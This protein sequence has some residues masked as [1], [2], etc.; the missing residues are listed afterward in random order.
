MRI[1][2]GDPDVVAP[3]L[4]GLETFESLARFL[5]A[6]E[7]VINQSQ[8]MIAR[9]AFGPGFDDAQRLLVPTFENLRERADLV[10]LRWIE[11]EYFC[12]LRLRVLD[13]AGEE[14]EVH[15]ILRRCERE[16]LSRNRSPLKDDR[17]IPP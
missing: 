7:P 3:S 9:I 8:A 16:W 6:A 1:H 10:G 14:Q 12:E 15:E 2:L 13:A 5:V 11:F 17:F 4:G